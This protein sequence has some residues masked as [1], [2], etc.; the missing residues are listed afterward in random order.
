MSGRTL[1]IDVAVA[2]TSSVLLAPLANSRSEAVSKPDVSQQSIWANDPAGF[3]QD[4]LGAQLWDGQIEI[5]EAVQDHVRVAVRSCNGSG[6]TYIAAHVV[7][8]WL[9]AFPE[10]MVITTAPTEWQ[11]REVL[12]HEIRRTYRGS[13][14]L[15]DGKLTRTALELGDKHYAHGISTN[16]PELRLLE[17]A[18]NRTLAPMFRAPGGPELRVHFDLGDIEALQESENDHVDRLV[19]LVSAG[20]LTVNEVRAGRGLGPVDWGDRPA[21][22]IARERESAASA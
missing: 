7:L 10:S 18:V 22:P 2:V 13:E 8:W 21:K 14:E 5:L 19:K 9:M 17:G 20:V 3:V 15:V 11:A 4:Q 1:V 6:K 16:E 12:W